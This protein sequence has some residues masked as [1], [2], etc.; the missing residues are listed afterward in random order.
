MLFYTPTP[1]RPMEHPQE[2]NFEQPRLRWSWLALS[3]ASL[4][5]GFLYLATTD[6][7]SPIQ[8]T[9]NPTEQQP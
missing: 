8:L 6:L 3:C 9:H 7:E 1:A 4:I 2:P 5:T